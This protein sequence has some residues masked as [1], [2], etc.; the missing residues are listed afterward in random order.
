MDY[1]L[2][3][4]RIWAEVADYDAQIMVA[5]RAY[6]QARSDYKHL[7]HRRYAIARAPMPVPPSL[8]LYPQSNPSFGDSSLSS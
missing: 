7:Q 5:L 1:V 4:A 2:R 6:D 3:A 8:G